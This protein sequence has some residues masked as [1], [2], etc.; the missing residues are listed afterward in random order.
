MWP[1]EELCRSAS[2][3]VFLKDAVGIEEIGDDDGELTEIPRPLLIQFR[4]S[5]KE[6]GYRTIFQRTHIVRQ[7]APA[8]Q[9]GDA[10]IAQH[11]EV[12]ARELFSQR[13]ENRKSE[14]EV[15]D[16]SASYD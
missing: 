1:G 16:G 3:D 11:C 6:S 8:R 13:A 12:C 14:N 2:G 4:V 9:F 10:R 15:A 5:R 7:P